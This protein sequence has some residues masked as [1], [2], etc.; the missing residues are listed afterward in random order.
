MMRMIIKRPG[1]VTKKVD[2]SSQQIQHSIGQG[3]SCGRTHEELALNAELIEPT[4]A[5]EKEE[6]QI[7][8]LK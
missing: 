2:L 5:K 8:L 3:T 1:K 6:L 4:R 7:C